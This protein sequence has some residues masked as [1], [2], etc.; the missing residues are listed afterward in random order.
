M[1]NTSDHSV[2]SK[3]N[4]NTPKKAVNIDVPKTSEKREETQGKNES[5]SLSKSELDEVQ[6]LLNL[7]VDHSV[8][9]NMLIEMVWI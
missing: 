7:G 9:L 3:L 4:Q 5:Y 2:A 6:R 1:K 8:H